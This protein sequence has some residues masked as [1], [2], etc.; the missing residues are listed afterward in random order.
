[1]KKRVISL[2]FA[3]VML[4]T[5]S[6][7]A[8]ATAT[9][10]PLAPN[11]GDLIIHKYAL[12]DLDDA[13][14]STQGVVATDIPADAQ[15]VEGI[16]FD[17]YK[18]TVAEGQAIPIGG[19]GAAYRLVTTGN[20]PTDIKALPYLE[21]TH[22][23]KATYYNLTKQTSP[24]TT[25]AKGVLTYSNL[26]RGYYFVVENLSASTPKIGGAAVSFD[27]TVNPF[28]VAVPMTNPAGTGWLDEVHVYPKNQSVTIEKSVDK[29]SVSVG[30]EVTYT[31]TPSVPADIIDAKQYTVT[32]ILDAA[33][34]YKTGSVTAKII[35]GSNDDDPLTAE[36]S[37]PA[38]TV[39]YDSGT[40]EIAF[41]AAGRTKLDGAT[42]VKITFKANVNAEILNTNHSTHTVANT[43]TLTLTNQYDHTSETTSTAGK[44]HTGQIEIS[45]V[46]ENGTTALPGAK[47][48]I[49]SSEVN[50]KAGNYLKKD[51]AGN[52]VD[53][54][55]TGY[56]TANTWEVT[57]SDPDGIA[58][59]EGLADYID[60]D[61]V[62][63]NSYWIIE[64]AA[65]DGYNLL[66]DP[67]QITFDNTATEENVYTIRK[68][69]V[70][71]TEFILPVT[72]GTGTLLFTVAGI[73]LVG[74]AVILVIL[75]RKKTSKTN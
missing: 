16:A 40:L 29:T 30:D 7:T 75:S 13:L 14:A 26:A 23:G 15:A 59:F 48:Q 72:G 70:N 34:T 61:P 49:A 60:G 6:M 51:S 57:S 32:D 62:S 53:V 56:V 1:M 21:I 43:A 25:G 37:T 47:F 11:T 35:G 12:E 55:E 50:A 28:V 5:F 22:G 54:G 17:V 74:V 2:L 3:M 31:I 10:D 68:T 67:I 33:L 71:T 39:T 8:F 36:G 58:I 63:Y 45:K 27:S 24:G 19:T 73:A 69:V 66:G 38:Y 52:I 4:F 41:T 20:L 65:P 42:A 18:I 46:E 9:D 44:T 64:T